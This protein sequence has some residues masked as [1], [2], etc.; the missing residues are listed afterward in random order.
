MFLYL[1]NKIYLASALG[2]GDREFE[3]LYPDTREIPNFSHKAFGN[4]WGLLVS[5]LFILIHYLSNKGHKIEGHT[6]MGVWNQ[7]DKWTTL[8]PAER[9]KTKS[10]NSTKS[11]TPNLKTR[12]VGC[13]V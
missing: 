1:L 4:H 5:S 11:S 12:G 9:I 8:S 7:I 10:I 13:E 2:A 3:S 6:P